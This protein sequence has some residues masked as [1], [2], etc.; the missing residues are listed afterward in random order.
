MGFRDVEGLLVALLR[1]AASPVKAYAKVPTARPVEFFWVRRTG[2]P[3][4]GR[5][6]D[7]AQV[8]VTAW[9]GSSTRALELA[10]VARQVLIDA[11]KGSNGI[12]RAQING[13]Y[14]DPDPSSGVDRYTFTA[15]LNVRASRS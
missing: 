8:T 10:N 1:D 15:F 14:S 2:G 13:L 12:H 9:A 7:Q 5:V 4:T 3:V 6:L 11:A